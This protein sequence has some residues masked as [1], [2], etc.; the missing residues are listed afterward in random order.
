MWRILC[1]KPTQ[2]R[3]VIKALSPV[4]SR[5]MV[6]LATCAKGFPCSLMTPDLEPISLCSL[7]AHIITQDVLT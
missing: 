6:S 3:S 5:E 4:I 7:I 2:G 1:P